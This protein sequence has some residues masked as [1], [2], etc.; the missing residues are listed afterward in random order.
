MRNARKYYPGNPRAP[1]KTRIESCE[2]QIINNDNEKK[3]TA[4]SQR[5]KEQ[6][7]SKFFAQTR[8]KNKHE[9]TE[10]IKGLMT[11]NQDF[12]GLSVVSE[13]L[14]EAAGHA[15]PFS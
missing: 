10:A 5:R 12:L 15:E 4:I 2:I 7:R 8:R 14:P 9:T 11:N 6:S 3:A 1:L 13:V